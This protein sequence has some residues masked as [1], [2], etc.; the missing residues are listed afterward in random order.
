[1]SRVFFVMGLSELQKLLLRDDTFKFVAEEL[2]D[3]TARLT[4]IC[5]EDTMS[6]S[7]SEYVDYESQ[8]EI[9]NK[10]EKVHL[11][12]TE[13]QSN[14]ERFSSASCNCLTSKDTIEFVEKELNLIDSKL[15]DE[16]SKYEFQLTS[17]V[18]SSRQNLVPP[19]QP[20]S[21][22]RGHF[23]IIIVDG[24]KASVDEKQRSDN[25]IGTETNKRL[26]FNGNN[27]LPKTNTQTEK[28]M[29][30]KKIQ[31]CSQFVANRNSKE[32]L[33]VRGVSAIQESQAPKDV[34]SSIST[35]NKTNYILN[36][37]KVKSKRY[38]LRNLTAHE[39][40]RR[41]L[42][43]DRFYHPYISKSLKCLPNLSRCS[44]VLS[45]STDSSKDEDIIIVPN[46]EESNL[47]DQTVNVVINENSD[48]GTDFSTTHFESINNNTHD[49]KGI[50]SQSQI[51]NDCQ[52]TETCFSDT[53]KNSSC[54]SCP[55]SP[56]HIND[57]FAKSEFIS[58][59]NN[60]I[61][62][63][64]SPLSA[65]SINY[66]KLH[67]DLSSE[68]RKYVEK[69][70]FVN[71][72]TA[73]SYSVLREFLLFDTSSFEG[74]T[75][76][77]IERK[78]TSI[79]NCKESISLRNSDNCD[80][81]HIEYEESKCRSS[82]SSGI[83][84]NI[85]LINYQSHR[86]ES[87]ISRND[88]STIPLSTDQS[89]SS[90]TFYM[91][92]EKDASIS[93]EKYSISFP[94]S[95]ILSSTPTQTLINHP[96]SSLVP[97]S[98]SLNIFPSASTIN[99][100]PSKPSDGNKC[101]NSTV[102]HI[103]SMDSTYLNVDCIKKP[104]INKCINLNLLRNEIDDGRVDVNSGFE[105][106]P[107]FSP[108]KKSNSSR[109]HETVPSIFPPLPPFSPPHLP[110]LPTSTPPPSPKIL[111]ITP[112]I[113]KQESNKIFPQT[114][115]NCF[116]KLP[117]DVTPFD[118]SSDSGHF[119][120]EYNPHF[121]E[122]NKSRTI[123]FDTEMNS[124][125]W[126]GIDTNSVDDARSSGE[127]I[128]TCHSV[129]E[130]LS[131][132][133]Y[134]NVSLFQAIKGDQC[135]SSS[136]LFMLRRSKSDPDISPTLKF[137]K[138]TKCCSFPTLGSHL[139][140]Y[141]ELLNILQTRSRLSSVINGNIDS[142]K[143]ICPCENYLS[144]L[145]KFQIHE[146]SKTLNPNLTLH[147]ENSYMEL[148]SKLNIDHFDQTFMV[149]NSL[150][151]ATNRSFNLYNLRKIETEST[152][153]ILS[154]NQNPSIVNNE[155]SVQQLH[156]CLYESNKSCCESP[157]ASLKTLL[158][159][160]TTS[161]PHDALVAADDDDVCLGECGLN[162]IVRDNKITDSFL[163]CTEVSGD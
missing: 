66:D 56:L 111:N 18:N 114:Q 135:Y 25:F 89:Q 45:G 162:Y 118:L 37:P 21:S 53:Q 80:A 157:N 142:S 96:R 122:A 125:N 7:E 26:V 105:N 136:N 107:L 48:K 8:L 99:P 74:V 134:E 79:A 116:T 3:V 109:R 130:L 110:P 126:D 69:E 16:R 49:H 4:T 60:S 84:R 57:S 101:K 43:C 28:K 139:K 140:S 34:V 137:K 159:P 29:N 147:A 138:V 59:S 129:D 24:E 58:S 103:D 112:A 146:L 124:R 2:H 104:T 153:S 9:I 161:T 123:S 33:S 98:S 35:D 52:N 87:S 70:K 128:H 94:D 160:N 149:Q 31:Y 71:T 10:P 95:K 27:F 22:E 15:E 41:S 76:S 92:T 64:S 97:D 155:T 61:S 65:N 12:S 77:K 150:R 88:Q 39:N 115:L 82:V 148:P 54:K 117:P 23:T 19:K 44:D 102:L 5:D 47:H 152:N 72:N 42:P 143:Y 119:H 20:F 78:S 131:C 73:D 40:T 86:I 91:L 55:V 67:C 13:F 36:L 113:L 132:D 127:S 108:I 133:I 154:N 63:T 163:P 156:E 51:L 38:T 83:S 62:K 100:C 141:N 93:G 151:G 90:E 144:P 17:I 46:L 32:A 14:P 120:R 85:S 50:I 145:E 158:T 1:M 106:I 81:S 68:N 30:S 6:C 121:T 11:S 75:N